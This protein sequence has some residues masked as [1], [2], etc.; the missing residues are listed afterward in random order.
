MHLNELSPSEHTHTTTTQGI[1]WNIAS[2]P[3][4]SLLPPPIHY[5][6]LSSPEKKT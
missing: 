1:I 4:A 3:G 6:F 5:L 2:T